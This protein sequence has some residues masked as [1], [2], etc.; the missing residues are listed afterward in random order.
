MLW[1]SVAKW[2]VTF[3]YHE[4]DV[5]KEIWHILLSIAKDRFYKLVVLFFRLIPTNFIEPTLKDTIGVILP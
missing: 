2:G 4:E 1:R 3:I 5:S